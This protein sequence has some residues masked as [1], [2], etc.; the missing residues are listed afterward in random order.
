VEEIERKKL[1]VEQLTEKL[2]NAQRGQKQLYLILFQVI[3]IGFFIVAI[4]V[5]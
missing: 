3:I 2:E 1:N 5:E 4:S